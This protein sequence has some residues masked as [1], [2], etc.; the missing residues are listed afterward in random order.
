MVIQTFLL[1]GTPGRAKVFRS[2]LKSLPILS[3][4]YPNL[5]FEIK[6][7]EIN[8]KLSEIHCFEVGDSQYY[9]PNFGD[10]WEVNLFAK[11]S[12]SLYNIC[13][14]KSKQIS[15]NFRVNWSLLTL[16]IREGMSSSILAYSSSVGHG[17]KY[18][19]AIAHHCPR[20]FLNSDWQLWL[21]YVPNFIF[22]ISPKKKS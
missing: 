12:N 6:S 19:L 13:S 22:N 1:F 21:N 9:W 4:A 16:F 7:G 17:I 2:I 15:T 14:V 11:H 10:F 3:R 8:W 5:D 20:K 18:A